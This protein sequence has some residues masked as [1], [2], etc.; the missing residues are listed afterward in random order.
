MERLDTLF[1]Q[2]DSYKSIIEKGEPWTDPDFP[3]DNSVVEGIEGVNGWM[4]ASQYFEGREKI[5]DSFS[6]DDIEQGILGDCYLLAAVSA[7]A[8]FPGRVQQLFLQTNRNNAGCYVVRLFICG[9]YVNIHVDDY[10]PLDASS[11]L[12]FAGSKGEELW[13]MLVEKAWAK[14][15]GDFSRIEGGDSRETLAAIT[16]AP[17]EFYKH[18]DMSTEDLWKLIKTADETNCVMCTGASSDS[19]GI[20]KNHAYTLIN[21]Y[22]FNHEGENV[23]LLQIR[24]PWANTEWTGAWSDED[25]RWTPE[26]RKKF[27]HNSADDGL[28]FMPFDDFAK[29]FV[30]TFIARSRDGYHNSSL[31]VEKEKAFAMFKV[32]KSTKGFVSAY[33]VTRKLGEMIVPDY[34]VAQMTLELYKFDKEKDI[35]VPLKAACNNKVG[36]TNIEVELDKG[37]Y[38]VAA[39]YETPTKIPYISFS[40]YTDIKVSLVELKINDISE[41]TYEKL[42]ESI[43][44]IKT[45]YKTKDTPQKLFAGTF[46]TCL[47]G[48]RLFWIEESYN[49][50]E[51]Y[52][53]ENCRETRKFLDGC[54]ICKECVYEICSKCR[55]KEIVKEKEV[56]KCNGGHTMEFEAS[57]KEEIFFCEKCGKAYYSIVHRWQ[58]TSCELDICPLCIPSP[59]DF[60]D[61]EIPEIETC[62]NDHKLEFVKER[63]KTRGYD[64]SLCEKTRNA[65]NGRWTCYEC[66][67]N[68]C[69]ICKPN[70]EAKGGL[71]SIQ[72]RLI[73]CDKGH[74]LSFACSSPL[75][76]CSLRCD[77]CKEV[78]GA[79]NWRWNCDQCN[80]AVCTNCK[81]APEGRKD[82]ICPNSHMLEY[83]TLPKE[84]ATYGR[85]DYCL[86]SFKYEGGAYCCSPCPYTYCTKCVETITQSNL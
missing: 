85:C 54:W 84:R 52:I 86:K 4:R 37:I 23:R 74:A 71:L 36:Q 72:T 18:K 78:V 2:D 17:A 30:H 5:Y 57:E 63:T 51:T 46:R 25:S 14:V 83:T 13:V 20:V 28:F 32:K 27:N 59:E 22:E 62:Y 49:K 38:V 61:N 76:E 43:N 47:A 81:S 55:P 79:D 53:C 29:I 15:H 60:K 33:E 12:A 69:T 68:L 56:M 66:G 58:C 9:K 41:V 26:L 3:H 10:F 34:T 24:N 35:L 7:L 42:N 65:E 8:E 19:K 6:A 1:K 73:A 16:G 40:N 77:K 80:F 50:S 11:R 70:K 44:S 75:P 67:I 64:C 21:A 31:V 39:K 48:D 45:D 82:L